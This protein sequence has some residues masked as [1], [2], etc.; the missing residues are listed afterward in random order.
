MTQK[1]NFLNTKTMFN[2][3][4]VENKRDFKRQNKY[5][6]LLK[7]IILMYQPKYKQGCESQT[8]NTS[9]VK[10]LDNKKIFLFIAQSKL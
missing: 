9:N 6:I 1:N 2:A 8:E 3:K 4:P 10:I 7:A 5:S